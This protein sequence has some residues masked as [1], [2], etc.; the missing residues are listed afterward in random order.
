MDNQITF[1]FEVLN[2]FL[3]KL[4]NENGTSIDENKVLI[5]LVEFLE[6]NKLKTKQ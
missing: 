4:E 1:N 6:K 2:K 3:L 5:L